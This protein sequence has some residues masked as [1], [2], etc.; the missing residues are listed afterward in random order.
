[1]YKNHTTIINYIQDSNHTSPHHLKQGNCRQLLCSGLARGV[2]EAGRQGV[3]HVSADGDR[4]VGDQ[5]SN[6]FSARV[7]TGALKASELQL[8]HPKDLIKLFEKS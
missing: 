2:G 4:L 6:A 3:R 7:K 8:D 5:K 1:M